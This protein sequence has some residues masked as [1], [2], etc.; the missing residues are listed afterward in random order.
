MGRRIMT[1]TI[2]DSFKPYVYKNWVTGAWDISFY[3]EQNTLQHIAAVTWQGAI[4][5]VEWLYSVGQVGTRP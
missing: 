4:E 1:R 2:D 5:T 3:D